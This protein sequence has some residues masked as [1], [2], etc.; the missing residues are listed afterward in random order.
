MK[1]NTWE[2]VPWPNHKKE[3]GYRWVF[4]LK[5]R[6]NGYVERYKARLVAKGFTQ[7]EGID[8]L[9]TF[10]L[11][12]KMTTVKGFMEIIAAQNW[13]LF[14]IDVN[15]TFLH[16]DLNEEVYM[17]SPSGVHFPHPNMVCKI[18]ISL[19]GLKHTSRQSNTKLTE[20]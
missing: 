20:C 17:K 14:Q 10:S 1:T 2:L 5:L 19:Y 6:D 7:T 15:M 11:V 18:Q 3:I 9:D 12:V 4:K 8:Y 16:G 13:P